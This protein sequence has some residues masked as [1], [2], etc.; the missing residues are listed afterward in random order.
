MAKVLKVRSG[1]ALS[2]QFHR[3]KLESM[4]FVSGSVTLLLGGKAVS[5]RPGLAVTIS[6]GTV[7]LLVA[8]SD[9]EVW[10]VSTPEVD[11][12]VRVADEYGRVPDGRGSAG[13]WAD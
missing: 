6:P 7:H 4:Y 2:L 12:V 3:R 1:H 5:I 13:G 10:E 11:D 8:D 9:V